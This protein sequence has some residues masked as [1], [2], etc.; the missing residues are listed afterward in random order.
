M[1]DKFVG[2]EVQGLKELEAQLKKL[3]PAVQD[4]VTDDANK[5]MLNV[6]RTYPAQKSISREQAYGVPFFTDKQRRYFFWAL[7]EGIISVPYRRTQELRRGWKQVG[8][9]RKSFLANEVPYSP[10][11]V[12]DK[13][14]SR[15]AALGGWK[16]LSAILKERTAAIIRVADAA[17]KKAIR[18]LGLG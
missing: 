17:A 18:K 1:V 11:M 5:Y 4:L 9:G 7:G 13:D 16:N 8:T 15:M 6:L 3:P 14:Q 2:I 10:Y 12:D